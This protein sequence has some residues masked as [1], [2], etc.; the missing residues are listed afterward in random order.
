MSD[1]CWPLAELEHR[2]AGGDEGDDAHEG[3]TTD[4]DSRGGIQAIPRLPEAN[5]DD[6]N[7]LVIANQLR[8]LHYK[9]QIV[10]MFSWSNGSL[11]YKKQWWLEALYR[12]DS[13][14]IV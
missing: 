11:G 3:D 7:R 13:F 2:T 9:N 1:G 12:V 6:L 4:M 5:H 14:A 10:A 8:I